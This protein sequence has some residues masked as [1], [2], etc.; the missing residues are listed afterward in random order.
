MLMGIFGILTARIFQII[1]TIYLSQV[2]LG[3][4]SETILE[5]TYITC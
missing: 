1:E 5:S 2:I 4:S 3:E